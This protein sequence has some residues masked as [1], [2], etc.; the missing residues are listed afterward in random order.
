MEVGEGKEGKKSE[1]EEGGM[2]GER[3]EGWSERK[4]RQG[5]KV[6]EGRKRVRYKTR[7]IPP[8][9]PIGVSLT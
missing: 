3:R 8:L 6:D 2:E 4:G 7:V 1:G 5:R 9:G